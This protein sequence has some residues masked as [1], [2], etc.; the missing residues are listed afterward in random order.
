VEARANRWPRDFFQETNG[1]SD[2]QPLERGGQG[3]F[4]VREGLR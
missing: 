1:A 4:E 2:D 3:V